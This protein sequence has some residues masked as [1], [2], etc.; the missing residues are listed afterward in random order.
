M[1]DCPASSVLAYARAWAVPGARHLGAQRT[2]TRADKLK[3]NN[4]VWKTKTDWLWPGLA[5]VCTLQQPVCHRRETVK[6]LHAV[7]TSVAKKQSRFTC[8]CPERGTGL[9]QSLGGSQ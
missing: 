9:T 7:R 5:R 3:L 2:Y 4:Q 1:A 8:P 6:S